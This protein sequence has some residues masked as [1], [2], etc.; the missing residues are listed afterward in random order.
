MSELETLHVNIL[1]REYGV[2]CPPEEVEELRLRDL[3]K[4]RTPPGSS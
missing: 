4:N 1:D 3:L 2:S